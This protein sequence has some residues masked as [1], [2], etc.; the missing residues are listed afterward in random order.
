MYIFVLNCRPDNDEGPQNQPEVSS[1]P[2]SPL[3][4]TAQEIKASSILP[5]PEIESTEAVGDS[6]PVSPKKVPESGASENITPSL[7]FGEP[8]IPDKKSKR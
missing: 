2:P 8:Q 1:K 6:S 3:K 5:V 4:D 7:V